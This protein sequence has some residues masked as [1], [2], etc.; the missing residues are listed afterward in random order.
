MSPLLI[1]LPLLSLNAFGALA[2]VTIARTAPSTSAPIATSP[3]PDTLRLL[4]CPPNVTYVADGDI[5]IDSVPLEL[6]TYVIKEVMSLTIVCLMFFPLSRLPISLGILLIQD[7]CLPHGVLIEPGVRLYE[8]G[9]VTICLLTHGIFLLSFF[10][11]THI[12]FGMCSYD[13]VHCLILLSLSNSS[14]IGLT[15]RHSPSTII[16]QG[17]TFL[18]ISAYCFISYLRTASPSNQFYHIGYV[19]LFTHICSLLFYDVLR[20]R[21]S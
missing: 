3:L 5:A 2:Q 20:L 14:F 11:R 13:W 4:V 6:V 15:L 1:A 21:V 7:R 18:L 8:G 16:G 10:R 17:Y 12:L 19:F 9:N